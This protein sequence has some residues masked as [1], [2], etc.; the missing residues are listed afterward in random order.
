MSHAGT[1]DIS[2]VGGKGVDRGRYNIM[3]LKLE[4]GSVVDRIRYY[5]HTYRSCLRN[6]FLNT[7][8]RMLYV[9][10]AFSPVCIVAYECGIRMLVP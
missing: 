7:S 4:F 8:T 6:P 2:S 1:P 10:S 3:V 5:W 9:T